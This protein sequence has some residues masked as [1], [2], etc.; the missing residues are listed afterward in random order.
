MNKPPRNASHKPSH[1]TSRT[2]SRGGSYDKPGV[3]HKKPEPICLEDDIFPAFASCAR[4]LEGLLARELEGLGCYTCKEVFGGV[5]FQ[6]TWQTLMRANLWTR[7]AGRI[8][9]QIAHGECTDEHRF[10]T[11]ALKQAWQQWFDVNQTFRVDLNNLGT[12]VPS[13]RFAQL[14][15]KDAICDSFRNAVGER[16]SVSID[17]PDVRIFAGLSATH[18]SIYVDLSGESLFK[19]GW[20]HD[21]GA[22]PLKET[23]AAGVVTLSGWTPDRVLLDPFCGSGTI[24]IEAACWAANK[25]PGLDR[26]FGFEALKP[27]QVGLWEPIWTDASRQFE[28]GLDAL[29][30]GKKP[31]AGIYGSDITRKLV[32]IARDNAVAA[33]LEPL[34]QSGHLK[35]SQGDARHLKAPASEGLL[36]CNPPY[37]ERVQ[38]K[39][40]AVDEEI[41]GAQDEAYLELFKAFGT[42]LK[43]NF[44]GWKVSIL[45]GDLEVRKALG[46]SPKRKTP[47]FNG[48]IECRLFE[49]PM[50]AGVYRPR[51]E[52]QATEG[53]LTESE[54]SAD[55][56]AGSQDS[57]VRRPAGL[58]AEASED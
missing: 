7:F 46:L 23:L 38:A 43:Q 37:G 5:E 29:I 49:F 33:G 40:K 9:L 25:A 30:S 26:V 55:P 47:L 15:L 8:G 4:G 13:L 57:S 6:A 1:S 14:R 32:D 44:S 39:G 21:K 54:A 18:A 52:N 58:S 34:M 56:S 31:L 36:L 51:A 16:P 17:A 50:A 11:F 2:P 42:Q 10:Y 27:H 20:R 48:A 19:R 35:F 24:P 12:Q 41:D 53:A 45:S 28:K 3:G 22:A